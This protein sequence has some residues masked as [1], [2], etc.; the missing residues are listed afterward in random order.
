MKV[1]HLN[2]ELPCA[3]CADVPELLVSKSFTASPIL[4]F[5]WITKTML[6]SFGV[7]LSLLVLLRCTGT[8][9]TAVETTV[10]LFTGKRILGPGNI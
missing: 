5:R 8:G 10:V 7:V 3:R 4:I 1:G 6:V 9:S 2:W